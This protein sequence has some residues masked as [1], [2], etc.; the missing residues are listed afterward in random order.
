LKVFFEHPVDDELRAQALFQAAVCEVQLD[1]KKA[2]IRDFEDVI[3][4]FPQ[5]T[6]A[7]RAREEL[8]KLGVSATSP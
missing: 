1:R 7:P 6:L 4:S 3:K 5:S 8:Q 2:A